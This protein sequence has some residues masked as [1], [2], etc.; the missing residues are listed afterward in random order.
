MA[1][2]LLF[3]IDNLFLAALCK[4]VKNIMSIYEINR[5]HIS[6]VLITDRRR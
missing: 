4:D 6:D 2:L 3:Y 5:N 1:I